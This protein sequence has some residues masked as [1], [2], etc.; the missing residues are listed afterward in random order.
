[1][2]VDERTYRGGEYHHEA[3]RNDDGCDHDTQVFSHS[4]GGDYGVQREHDVEQHD[5]DQ[6]T[7]E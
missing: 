5:L 6:H 1:V 3:H 2:P 4:N 7:C